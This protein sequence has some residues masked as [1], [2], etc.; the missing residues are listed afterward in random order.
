MVEWPKVLPPTATCPSPLPAW[1]RNRP[2][3]C[4]KVVS[5]FGVRWWFLMGTSVSLN[6]QTRA[7][8]RNH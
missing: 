5:D 2:G 7:V 3:A 8:N 4:E 1:V 6:L